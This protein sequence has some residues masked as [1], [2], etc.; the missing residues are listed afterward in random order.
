MVAATAE[1][2]DRAVSRVVDT[3]NC[4]G[5]GAC[6]LLDP[7][8]EM[9]LS[10]DGYA[11]PVRSAREP[12]PE[13]GADATFDRICPGRRVV[14]PRPAGATVHPTLGPVVSGWEAWAADPE[15]RHRGSSGGTLT[16]LVAWLT[17]NG[18]QASFTGARAAAAEPRRTVSV[19]ITSRA[20]ALA[21]AGSRYAPVASVAAPGALAPGTGLVGK[22][23]EISAARALLDGAPAD[24]GSPPLLLSFFC[25]GTPSQHATDALVAQLGVP[26]GAPLR[27]LWY[28]G[29]GWPGHFTAEAEDGSTVRT[30]YDES[31]GQHLGKTTQWRCKICPDG[32]GESSD[33]TA[34][35]F[36]HTDAR[37]YP[38]FA[39]GDGCSAV[40]AR[41]PRG[42]EVLQRAFA[43]GVLVGRSLDL[44]A[45][46]DVQPLQVSRRS[47]LLGRLAGAR[48]AGRPVPRYRGFGLARLALADWRETARTAKGSFRRV[49]RARSTPGAGR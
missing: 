44:D 8:L 17:E 16:A 49:Q 33:I 35:D 10:A 14:S 48:L 19:T 13:P 26:A 46:A 18:E 42:H 31:W 29:R 22:P 39:E 9:A 43:A 38:V 15:I 23:C 30:T 20:E 47:T 1:A 24:A 36:W 3:A 2:L 45:L 4:S 27:D 6:T 25:A 41:T 37:G 34:A 40:L 28:R 11:R 32:V 7:G 5:C 12:A 21:S